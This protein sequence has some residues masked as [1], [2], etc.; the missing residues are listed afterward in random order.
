M[1]PDRWGSDHDF[2]EA[3]GNYDRRP[4]TPPMALSAR[5]A[6][7]RRMEQHPNPLIQ[8]M[9]ADLRKLDAPAGPVCPH[10]IDIAA[11]GCGKCL[12]SLAPQGDLQSWR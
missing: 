5:E 9:A 3:H 1:F 7:L 2:A 10:G 11:A 6:S 4:S 8:K 12:S